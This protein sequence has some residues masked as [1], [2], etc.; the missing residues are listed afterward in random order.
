[1]F[2]NLYTNKPAKEVQVCMFRTQ[3]AVVFFVYKVLDIFDCFKYT[4][5][6]T[7]Q[8]FVGYF[9]VLFCFSIRNLN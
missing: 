8:S 6:P 9:F 2:E 5:A 3:R 7:R 4:L 1:M